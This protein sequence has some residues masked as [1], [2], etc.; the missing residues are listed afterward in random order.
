MKHEKPKQSYADAVSDLSTRLGLLPNSQDWAIESADPDRLSEFCQFALRDT[1]L[2][3]WSRR[4]LL[5]LIIASLDEALR[6]RE[7]SGIESDLCREVV[8]RDANGQPEVIGYWLRLQ[9]SEAD[10]FPAADWLRR[11]LSK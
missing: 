4:L 10:P 2:S 3:D 5:E 6:E 7:L 1:G 11:E 9:R 8:R